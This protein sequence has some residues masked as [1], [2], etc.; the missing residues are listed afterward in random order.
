MPYESAHDLPSFVDMSQ[1]VKSIK[2]LRF[3]LPKDQRKAV[4]E[5]EA[6]LSF[7]GDTVDRF[8]SVLGPR[9]WVF[10][11]SLFVDEIAGLLDASASPEEAER[12][13]IEYYRNPEKLELMVPAINAFQ[14]LRK[15]KHLVRRAQDDYLAGRYYACTLVLLTV[16]DGFVNEFEAVRRGL[17]AREAE[18]L[19]AFD[20][21]V[22]HHMGLTSAQAT[23]R[24]SKGATST[25]PVYELYRNG[26][27]HG[28]LLNYDNEVVATKA[29]N[30]LFAVIDWAKTRAK[31]RQPPPPQPTWRELFTRIADHARQERAYKEWKPKTLLLSDEGFRSH[32]V[33]PAC[34]QLLTFWSQRNYGRIATL[35]SRSVQDAYG[36]SMPRQVRNEYSPYNL[37]SFELLK[38]DETAPAV[39]EVEALLAFDTGEQK[40]AYLRWIYEDDAGDYVASSLPGGWRLMV[41]GPAGFFTEPED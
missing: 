17:H 39:C 26:I 22:G 29:W 4:K 24:R 1:Q 16:M 6:Q 2:L 14:E 12:N 32:P 40:A 19:D 31:E 38:I 7:L 35:L 36:G 21:V 30:R 10:H 25:D 33:H 11:D 20:S 15:R 18:E 28:T 27:I 13:L 8:Y 9:N 34:E 3:I 41:W 23:F 5:L 37:S